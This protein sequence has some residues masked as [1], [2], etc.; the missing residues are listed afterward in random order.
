MPTLWLGKLLKTT[1][2]FTGES[3]D[4]R[5]VSMESTNCF[6]APEYR[7]RSIKL[8]IAEVLVEVPTA[9]ADAVIV[10]TNMVRKRRYHINICYRG[11]T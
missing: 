10:F 6:D 2:S 8:A 9:D 1:H 3:H 4:V 11:V 5:L 7:T